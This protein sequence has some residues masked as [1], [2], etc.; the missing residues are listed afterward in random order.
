[1]IER[2]LIAGDCIVLY[3]GDRYYSTNRIPVGA[4][5]WAYETFPQ[6]PTVKQNRVC[7]ILG[8]LMFAYEE[9][10]LLYRLTWL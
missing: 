6:D 2:E 9:D 7:H 8:N 5:A 4:T 10:Y 3:Y 1:M